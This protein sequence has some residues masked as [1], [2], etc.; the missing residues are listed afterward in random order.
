MS[1][2]LQN[3]KVF[4]FIN[5]KKEELRKVFASLADAFEQL[6]PNTPLKLEVIGTLMWDVIKYENRIINVYILHDFGLENWGSY[7]GQN[8]VSERI[9]DEV[10]QVLDVDI[11]DI[12]LKKPS[13]D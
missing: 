3:E 12:K 2:I 11:G 4:E 7:G 5:S 10:F 1:N 6:F 13:K 8:I 9:I